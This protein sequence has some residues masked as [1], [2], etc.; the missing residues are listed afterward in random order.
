MSRYCVFE[1]TLMASTHYAERILD[2][3]ATEDIENGTFGYLDGLADGESNIYKFVKGFKEGSPVV[4]VDHPAWTEDTS[5]LTNQRRD[6]Y[7]NKA[8]VPFRVRV[9]KKLDEFGITIEGITSATQ[10][11]VTDVTDFTA[12]EI[13]VTIDST[14]G[15]LVAEKV[16]SSGTT[17]S[18]TT[19]VFKARIMRKRRMGASLSTPLRTYGYATAIYEAKI[20]AL[21]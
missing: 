14:T 5:K 1:S 21:A 17:A 8:D 10:K 18:T 3:I 12:D 13:N 9:V 16:T 6:N 15:K 2:A 19:S 11:I 7:I 4:V 20:I